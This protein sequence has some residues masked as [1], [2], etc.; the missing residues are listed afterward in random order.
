ML[1]S[2]LTYEPF[3][4]V[5]TMALGNGLSVANDWGNDG[6][7][8]SRRL[9]VTSSGVNRSWLAYAYDA[10]DN[11]GAI[12]DEPR[13]VRRRLFGLSHAAKAGCSSAA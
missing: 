5:K 6:R 2:G 4:S 12:K 7:L 11:L 1:A 9:Y 3:G 8:A 10:N 13:R